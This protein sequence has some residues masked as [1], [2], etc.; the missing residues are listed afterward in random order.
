M[1]E[2]ATFAALTAVILLL[3]L[4][5]SHLTNQ[6][7]QAPAPAPASAKESV[8]EGP[9]DLEGNDGA[10]LE[11]DE[12]SGSRPTVSAERREVDAGR[13]SGSGSGSRAGADS[14]TGL[15][16]DAE[17]DSESDPNSGETRP[18]ETVPI[19]QSYPTPV[20]YPDP[21]EHEHEHVHPQPQPQP[22]EFDPASLS[23]G[24]LLANVAFSQGLF[25]LVLI[26]AAVYTGI[27]LWAFG[28]ALEAEYVLWGLILG[29][30]VGVVLYGLNELG[31]AGIKRVGIDHS[32]HLRELLAPDTRRGWLVLL[33]V[34][35]P[36]IAIF[37]ELLFRAALIGVLAAGFG[38]SP[39]LLAV[40]SS[41][42]FALGHGIQ[43]TAGIIVTGTLGFVLAAVFILTGSFLVVVVAHYL[44]NALEFVVHE[45]L[46]IEWAGTEGVE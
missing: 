2:W 3:L 33:L 31:A 5:L 7:L 8:G 39:W 18:A 42:V 24:A 44:I 9:V 6:T 10:P 16:S 35:L 25:A 14:N 34:V 20:E 22:S 28:I 30:A 46:E 26:G 21:Q 15:E 32:E 19:K 38:I 27:P 29:T 11:G 4:V 1:P 37:E 13:T 41:V 17:T 12:K 36:I 43:G 45:G 40:G 23:T